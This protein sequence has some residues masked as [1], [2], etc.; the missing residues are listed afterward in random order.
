MRKINIAV[1]S[2]VSSD[3]IAGKIAKEI[4]KGSALGIE[5]VFELET[6][7]SAWERSMDTIKHNDIDFFVTLASPDRIREIR[8]IKPCKHIFTVG[9]SETDKP[10]L[11]EGFEEGFRTLRTLRYNMLAV[12]NVSGAITD[13]LMIY[14][15]KTYDVFADENE[16]IR[17]LAANM[18]KRENVR[19]AQSIEE[20]NHISVPDEVYEKF[21]RLGK[22]LFE[23]GLLPVVDGGTYGNFSMMFGGSM[24]ITGRGSD[25]GDL[26]RDHIVRI[27]SVEKIELTE[28]IELDHL[29]KVFARIFYSGK[30]KPSIDTAI[31]HALLEGTEFKATVHI[32]TDRIFA[33]LPMTGYNYPCGAKEELDEIMS[34]ARKNPDADILQQYKHGLIILGNDFDDCIKKIEDLFSGGIS[35]RKINEDEKKEK[36]F[37]EWEEHYKKNTKGKNADID[38]YDAKNLYVIQKGEAKVGFLYIR[39]RDDTI[40]FVFYSLEEFTR[41]KLGLGEKVIDIVSKIARSE[42]CGRIGILTTRECNVIPYYERKGFRITSE[43]EGGSVWMQKEMQ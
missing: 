11:E 24:Y 19:H 2:D 31:N 15:E 22:T 8:K 4:R 37:L 5:N 14:P 17:S 32:H 26:P 43:D 21:H 41:K 34:L 10:R 12:K 38:I 29:P 7:D 9:Y 3:R 28:E 30:V 27:N 39:T 20:E 33:D 35:A 36:E 42:Q 16:W 40:Y 1:L 18:I 6:K 23:K 13:F 25:K